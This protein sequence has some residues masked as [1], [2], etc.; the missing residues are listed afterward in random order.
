[1]LH[2]MDARHANPATMTPGA[3][4]QPDGTLIYPAETGH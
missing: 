3:Q 1:M 4:P 2:I